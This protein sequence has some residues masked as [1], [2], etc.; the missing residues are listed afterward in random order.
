MPP[1]DPPWAPGA[2]TGVGPMPG[3][4]PREAARV[5]VGE[6][7][8]PHVP[9][10]PAR[11]AGA[12]PAG[13]TAAMLV[14]LHVDIHAGRWRLV[15]RPSADERRA[16]ELLERDLDA[17]EE[18]A[19]SH[20][21]PVKVQAVGP[22]SLAATL[23]LARGEKVLA[24]HG[25]AR[26]LA[27]SLSEGLRLHVADVRRR[28]SRVAGVVVQIDEP[29]LPSVLAGTVPTA[30]GWARLPRPEPAPA[31]QALAEILAAAGEDAG[32]RCDRLGAPLALFRRAGARFVGLDARHLD[33]VPEEDLGQAIEEGMG[34]L[35]GLVPP[36]GRLPRHDDPADVAAEL[37]GPA[38]RVWNRLGLAEGHWDRVVVTP[39]TDLSE[40]DLDQAAAVLGCCTATARSLQAPEGDTHAEEL[41]P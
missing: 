34:V 9:E 4:D 7:A 40:L 20:A 17:L 5:V 39:A 26:E 2:A 19:G 16:R 35:L 28:L 21:G 24:D 15:P 36:P 6:V 27:A 13:R 33:T 3:T 38:R 29:L 23:E 12:D 31:E 8:V 30:S 25:A 22:W 18:V 11:G 10:L 14:D 32:V 37:A 1:W 41:D